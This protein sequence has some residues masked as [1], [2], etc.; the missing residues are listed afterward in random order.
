[1][2]KPNTNFKLTV[3]DLDII[4]KALEAKISRRAIYLLEKE[5]TEKQK[6]LQELRD[7][8]GRIHQQKNWYRPNKGTYVSG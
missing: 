3:K 5:D 7:L 4:E 1:M 8:L 2:A 6:E